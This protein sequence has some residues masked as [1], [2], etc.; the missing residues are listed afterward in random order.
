MKANSKLD[1]LGDTGSLLPSA[2]QPLAGYFVKFIQAYASE[3]V[4]ISAIAPENEPEAESAFPAMYFPEPNEALWISQDLTPALAAA[5]LKP[6]VYGFDSSWATPAYPQ[7]L[8][9]S[10]AA[11][12][13]A[14]IAW[15]CYG[16]IPTAMSI[17]QSLA[18][19]LDQL[20]TECAPNLTTIPVPEIVIGAMRNW[21]NAVTLWNLAL[22]PSGA[23]VQLPNSAC[24][25][26]TGLVTI[27]ETTHN[28]S[29]SLSYYQL[30]Q[31][32]SFVEPGAWRISSNS[33]VTYYQQSHTNYGATAGLDDVAFVN[34]DGSRV[35]V[36]YNNSSARIRFAVEWNRRAF[37]YTPAPTA[38]VSFEWN[39]NP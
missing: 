20:V 9:A 37:T 18:P 22:D 35:L 3:G 30:G 5:N 24:N 27:N 32:G 23:P 16:G 17:L 10:G 1:D 14:R 33:Y 6:K 15:H 31:I 19:T 36:A 21:A 7:A 34:P 11:N 2:Y 39:P 26:C 38:T 25:G 4:P 13:L 8:I 28:V 12:T 29:F